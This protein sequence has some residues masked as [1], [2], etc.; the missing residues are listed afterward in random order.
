[1]GGLL[2]V[3]TERFRVVR[4]QD[5]QFPA[6]YR[7]ICN[8]HVPEWTDLTP[9]HR[10][11]CM[12]AVAAIETVLRSELQPAKVNLASFGNVVPH[13]HWHV[14][15]RFD[16]DTHFPEPYWGKPQRPAHEAKLQDLTDR[17]PE[18]DA[19]LALAI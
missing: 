10:G 9:L 6:Y 8:E 1:V 5:A 7:L 13:L 12:H 18:V 14:M 16:W 17:M 2:V 11:E 3:R 15:A 19:A 4:V